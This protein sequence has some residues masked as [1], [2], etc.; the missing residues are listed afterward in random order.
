MAFV[1]YLPANPE[2]SVA[3]ELARAAR[4]YLRRYNGFSYDFIQGGEQNLLCS[5]SQLDLRVFFDVGANV[6]NWARTAST[7]FPDAVFHTFEVSEFNYAK[8]AS[9]LL[10]RS[11]VHNRKG[12]LNFNGSMKYKDY[13]EGSGLNTV[14]PRSCIH[15][16]S[17]KPRLKAVNVTTGDKYCVDNGIL[18][19]DFLKVDVE[20]AENLVLEGFGS[21]LAKGAIRIIQFE[22]G[23]ANGDSHFLMRDFFDF[24][25]S[26]GYV[27]SKVRRNG[28][29]FGD[30]SYEMN[31]FD[32]G[33][34]YL[35][36]AKT[37]RQVLDL[38]QSPC[39]SS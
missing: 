13:G 29:H 7:F 39:A 14:I 25:L 8:M 10:G 11:F 19:V 4:R 18:R 15:D 12:L 30:F 38:L 33:P 17:L 16:N 28:F 34:N 9:S 23:F 24:F 31:N 22:Y 2:S 21:L 37:D 1:D 32:S 5:L 3:R 26:Y 20:G 35:A 6:G 36:V 27:L